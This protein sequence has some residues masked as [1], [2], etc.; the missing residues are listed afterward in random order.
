MSSE[1][2]QWKQLLF[3][4]HCHPHDTVDDHEQFSQLAVNKMALQGVNITNWLDMIH[5]S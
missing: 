2:D 1:S 4:S 5:V 3:D